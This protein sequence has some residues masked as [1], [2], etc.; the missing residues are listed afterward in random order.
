MSYEKSCGAVVFRENKVREY[1]IIFNKKGNAVG[2]WG[3]PKGHVEK[4]E[5]EIETAVREIFEETGLKPEFIEGFREMSR[6]SPKEGVDKEVVYFLAESKDDTV[7]IQESEL[8]DYRWC[9]FDEACHLLTFDENILKSA[10][11][12]LTLLS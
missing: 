9:V 4:N 5:T 12:F 10:E 8:S 6:Y 3:F 7:S 2:H 11:N 1:L